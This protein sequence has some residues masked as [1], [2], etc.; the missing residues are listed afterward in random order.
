MR[1]TVNRGNVATL[2]RFLQSHMPAAARIVSVAMLCGSFLTACATGQ[3]GQE[4]I[5]QVTAAVGTP[6][7]E[8]VC[9]QAC[10]QTW[11]DLNEQTAD[12]QRQLA[13]VR[14]LPARQVSVKQMKRLCRALGEESRTLSTLEQLSALCP[15]G[16]KEKANLVNLRELNTQREAECSAALDGLAQYRRSRT[17]MAWP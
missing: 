12:A 14:R 4:S 10:G 9:D 7:L 16:A 13:E 11:Q 6:E 3:T 17:E 1:K 2:R 5:A 15:F 8:H